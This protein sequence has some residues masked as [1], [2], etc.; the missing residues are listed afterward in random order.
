MRLS[1]L[2][3]VTVHGGG[4]ALSYAWARLCERDLQFASNRIDFR[5]IDAPVDEPVAVGTDAAQVASQGGGGGAFRHLPSWDLRR[6]TCD[7][8]DSA[9]SAPL[10]CLLP[11][12]VQEP[13][14]LAAEN[15]YRPPVV[16]C[17]QSQFEPV[18]DRVRVD[19][20]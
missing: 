11:P 7:A 8:I 1:L 14:Q 15:Q 12:L 5:E 18:A 2:A 6:A 10:F 4:R 13:Q 19:V 3:G 17:G 9:R 20:E 16:D